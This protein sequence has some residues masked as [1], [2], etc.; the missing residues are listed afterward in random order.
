[1]RRETMRPD[2]AIRRVLDQKH[3]SF[4]ITAAHNFPSSFATAAMM[5]RKLLITRPAKST[6]RASR[7]DSLILSDTISENIRIEG[8]R[9]SGGKD[10]EASPHKTMRRKQLILGG[11]LAVLLATVA[12]AEDFR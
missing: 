10:P 9:F 11:I 8:N 3:L 7:A 12:Q 5:I 6:L 2:S 1:M 4:R